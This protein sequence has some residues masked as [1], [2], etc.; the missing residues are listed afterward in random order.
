MSKIYCKRNKNMGRKKPTLWR[1]TDLFLKTMPNGKVIHI[2]RD[3][4]NVMASFKKFTNS[5]KPN[6]LS[7]A[8]NSLDAMIYCK[9]HLNHYN[10]KF[11]LIKY[12]DLLN[13]T[14]KT[15]FKVFN[16]FK[17]KKKNNSS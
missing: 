1:Q 5:R 15:M 8:L 7:S 14:S 11:L 16:F 6:Y 10:D 17:F 3:P 2:L 4:R 13:E 9:K 12:E